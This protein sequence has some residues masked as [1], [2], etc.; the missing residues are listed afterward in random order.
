MA[1]KGPKSEFSQRNLPKVG[2]TVSKYELGGIK[3]YWMLVKDFDRVPIEGS[4]WMYDLQG[5]LVFIGK[6]R[7]KE[8]YDIMRVESPVTVWHIPSGEFCYSSC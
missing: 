3:D 7:T 1:F 8:Y 2:D 4:S 6:E 5:T